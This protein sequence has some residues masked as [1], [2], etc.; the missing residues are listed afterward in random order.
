MKTAIMENSFKKFDCKKEDK[1][2]FPAEEGNLVKG[3]ALFFAFSFYYWRGY[4][5]MLM[6]RTSIEGQVHN[7]EEED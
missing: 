4:F 5:E 3:G 2:R 7:R 1:D 6:E